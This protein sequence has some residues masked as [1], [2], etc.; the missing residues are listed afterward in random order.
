MNN[1]GK[2]KKCKLEVMNFSARV[3]LRH[4][5]PQTLHLSA[6]RTKTIFFSYSKRVSTSNAQNQPKFLTLYLSLQAKVARISPPEALDALLA[7]HPDYHSDPSLTTLLTTRITGN[8]CLLGMNSCYSQLLQWTCPEETSFLAGWRTNS[9]TRRKCNQGERTALSRA[10]CYAYTPRCSLEDSKEICRSSYLSLSSLEDTIVVAVLSQW[11][12]SGKNAVK[13]CKIQ[14]KQAKTSLPFH[15]KEN[16]RF[17]AFSWLQCGT[18]LMA[19]LCQSSME[20]SAQLETFVATT[21]I[22]PLLP[23]VSSSSLECCSPFLSSSSFQSS[24]LSSE[25]LSSS[26][27]TSADSMNCEHTKRNIN[28]S[29]RNCVSFLKMKE[30]SL[31]VM[32]VVSE[33]KIRLRWSRSIFVSAVDNLRMWSFLYFRSLNTIPFYL[34]SYLEEHFFAAL[35]LYT[36]ILFSLREQLAASANEGKKP[37]VDTSF[38]SDFQQTEKEKET[39]LVVLAC[40]EQLLCDTIPPAIH[41]SSSANNRACVAVETFRWDVTFELSQLIELFRFTSFHDV[42][43]ERVSAERAARKIDT[44]LP[45]CSSFTSAS[46]LLAFESFARMVNIVHINIF[47]SSAY[48]YDIHFCCTAHP[49]HHGR[50]VSNHASRHSPRTLNHVDTSLQQMLAR[51]LRFWCYAPLSSSGHHS[52]PSFSPSEGIIYHYYRNSPR[53]PHSEDRDAMP[54]PGL[55]TQWLRLLP[56]LADILEVLSR[57]SF[58]PNDSALPNSLGSHSTLSEERDEKSE[59]GGLVGERSVP[60]SSSRWNL[61]FSSPRIIKE[62]VEIGKLQLLKWGTVILWCTVGEAGGFAWKKECHKMGWHG[63][64]EVEYGSREMH[65]FLFSFWRCWEEWIPRMSSMTQIALYRFLKPILNVPCERN[66]KKNAKA[67][68]AKLVRLR[69]SSAPHKDF[70]PSERT[71]TPEKLQ[72]AVPGI[73]VGNCLIQAWRQT[74]QRANCFCLHHQEVMAVISVLGDHAERRRRESEWGDSIP[75]TRVGTLQ[76]HFFRI[77]SCWLDGVL[78]QLCVKQLQEVLK[79]PDTGKPSKLLHCLASEP[80]AVISGRRGSTEGRQ[81]GTIFSPR[82]RIEDEVA[83]SVTSLDPFLFADLAPFLWSLLFSLKVRRTAQG[84]GE[85]PSSGAL[86]LLSSS[87]RSPVLRR[88]YHEIMDVWVFTLP[89]SLAWEGLQYK[90]GQQQRMVEYGKMAASGVVSTWN[91]EREEEE[92][93]YRAECQSLVNLSSLD[94]DEKWVVPPI[95]FLPFSTDLEK[96]EYTTN[97]RVEPPATVIL[98]FGEQPVLSAATSR[99]STLTRSLFVWGTMAH[100]F[101]SCASSSVSLHSYPVI[102]PLH[103]SLPDGHDCGGY[104]WT[105]GLGALVL[106]ARLRNVTSFGAVLPSFTQKTK[107]FTS[108]RKAHNSRINSV[109]PSSRKQAKSDDNTQDLLS[110]LLDKEGVRQLKMFHYL[111]HQLCEE[112]ENWI[113]TMKFKENATENNWR[114]ASADFCPDSSVFSNARPGSLA[115]YGTLSNRPVIGKYE[116]EEKPSLDFHSVNAARIASPHFL[117]HKLAGLSFPLFDMNILCIILQWWE[118]F[119]MLDEEVHRIPAAF[120]SSPSSSVSSGVS[121]SVFPPDIGFHVLHLLIGTRP[122]ETWAAIPYLFLSRMWEVLAT[123]MDSS[124]EAIIN[125]TVNRETISTIETITK[126]VKPMKWV[127]VQLSR[128]VVMEELIR[129]HRFLVL[130]ELFSTLSTW[131]TFVL[132]YYCNA[133]QRKGRKRSMNDVDFSPLTHTFLDLCFSPLLLL[134]FFFRKNRNSEVGRGNGELLSANCSESDVDLLN[135]FGAAVDLLCFFDDHDNGVLLPPAVIPPSPVI[136]A[137]AF[138]QHGIQPSGIRVSLFSSGRCGELCN[139]ERSQSW[140][141]IEKRECII[142]SIMRKFR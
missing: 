51:V 35:R 5:F 83:K 68:F 100:L 12:I 23:V 30:D 122:A 142:S 118:E 31:A 141:S 32:N 36:D 56:R 28:S 132:Q 85:H 34:W 124:C 26:T 88:A 58:F 50:D 69:Q 98:S 80:I 57:I 84:S 103:P 40:S 1:I 4:C 113:H 123:K 55:Q 76:R 44:A 97:E 117:F 67:E 61:D 11:E 21:I 25:P 94:D 47:Q 2:K 8:A 107:N 96:E 27:K 139:R 115:G 134:E 59:A 114:A 121:T 87:F 9:K 109:L 93:L 105:F 45:S 10:S 133:N 82:N 72:L 46:A 20:A 14:E 16:S 108:L 73:V 138:F 75:C 95:S 116:G 101:Q 77:P 131:V 63:A 135:Q 22:R 129:V 99:T 127:D 39:V 126:H 128:P 81:W 43:E 60:A 24:F 90:H 112:I 65:V 74:W 37:P 18:L 17:S 86:D 29:F 64:S 3:H 70:E 42:G 71:H 120:F 49:R 38:L 54:F 102:H 79:H 92:V 106:F 66:E 110:E 52:S 89:A 136:E 7:M 119:G 140:R 15:L 78:L 137:Y 6:L 130:S 62:L 104:R 125:S 111:Y 91:S 48:L 41:F 13:E 19:L 33:K 53:L